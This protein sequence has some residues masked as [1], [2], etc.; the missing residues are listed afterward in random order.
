M[1][2]YKDG[3]RDVDRLKAR[4]KQA[5]REKGSLNGVITRLKRQRDCLMEQVAALNLRVQ[6][7]EQPPDELHD[8]DGGRSE[9][10]NV[11]TPAAVEGSALP[12]MIQHILPIYLS[13][14]LGSDS[15]NAS[16]HVTCNCVLQTWRL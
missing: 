15:A 6:R 4:L 14:R 8:S 5:Q 12:G 11:D 16:N 10:T 9:T 7:A 2:A 13:S 1:G 3:N